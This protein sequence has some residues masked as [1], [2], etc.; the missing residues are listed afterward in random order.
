MFDLGIIG[1]GP[2]GY[3]A[4]EKAGAAGLSVVLFEKNT[5]GGVCLN[6][7]CI[8]TK[9]MLYSA[10]L[11]DNAR[12]SEKYGVNVE[13]ATIDYR[14]ILKRKEKVV[15]KLVG[16]VKVAMRDNA[17]TVV[18]SEAVIKERSAE[19]T[20]T[21]NSEILGTAYNLTSPAAETSVTVNLVKGSAVIVDIQN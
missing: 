2:G 12:H 18:N 15:R 7:G 13:N 21:V 3:V 17:V 14:T 1:G 20:I 5:L 6:E 19:G 10:K 4:A 9:T 8:P 16:A 11:Y